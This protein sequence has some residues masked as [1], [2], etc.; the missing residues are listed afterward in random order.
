VAGRPLGELDEQ[1]GSEDV[2]AGVIVHYGG[3][4]P[5]YAFEVEHASERPDLAGRPRALAAFRQ[6]KASPLEPSPEHVSGFR[7]SSLR[8]AT[9]WPRTTTGPPT[10]CGS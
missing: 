1:V 5:P 10:A 7:L 2:E 3:E 6:A 8:S 9:I 4:P